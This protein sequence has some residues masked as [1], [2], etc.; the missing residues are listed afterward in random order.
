MCPPLHVAGL[1]QQGMSP[2][3]ALVIHTFIQI[4][5]DKSLTVRVLI[6]IF[7]QKDFFSG[8][9]FLYLFVS[10][11]RTYMETALLET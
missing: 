9:I 10:C 7:V 6:L 3:G 1:Q 4:T 8:I 2:F 5:T 11:M